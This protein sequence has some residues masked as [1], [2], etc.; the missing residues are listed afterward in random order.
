[1]HYQYSSLKTK[2]TIGIFVFVKIYSEQKVKS[3]GVHTKRSLVFDLN[4][5]RQCDI[6]PDKKSEIKIFT[7]LQKP[8]KAVQ[9]VG[10]NF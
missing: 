2:K 8:S 6:H 1:M 3:K 5:F 10:F 7:S 9:L 4:I